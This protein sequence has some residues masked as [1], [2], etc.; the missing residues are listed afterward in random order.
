MHRCGGQHLS[1]LC[2]CNHLTWWMVERLAP[3]ELGRRGD[4]AGSQKSWAAMVTRRGPRRGEVA[5]G[6]RAERA[7]GVRARVYTPR[8]YGAGKTQTRIAGLQR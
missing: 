1:C 6:K 7:R 5:G 4:E 8:R 2:S 3:C